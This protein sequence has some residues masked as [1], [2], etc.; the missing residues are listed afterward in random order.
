MNDGVQ[1]LMEGWSRRAYAYA[2]T[3]GAISMLVW[4]TSRTSARV[5]PYGGSS[6]LIGLGLLAG[7][8]HPVRREVPPPGGRHRAIPPELVGPGRTHLQA[9]DQRPE[10]VLRVRRRSRGEPAL[11]AALGVSRHP[12]PCVAHAPTDGERAGRGDRQG[13]RH[14]PAARVVP[15]PV[16]REGRARPTSWRDL[17]SRHRPTVKRSPTCWCANP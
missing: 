3:V 1:V 17:S 16:P 11:C 4:A 15:S 6:L 14:Q 8:K 5:L 9:G 10:P 2:S 13:A 7:L 12:P